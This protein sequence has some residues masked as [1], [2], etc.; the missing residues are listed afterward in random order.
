LDRGVD[1]GGGTAAVAA[2]LLGGLA[3][4]L[5]G[6]LAAL[7]WAC[8]W[9]F[10]SSL[11]V[12]ASSVTSAYLTATKRVLVMSS[13]LSISSLSLMRRRMREVFSVMTTEPLSG[14]M[15]P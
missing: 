7:F 1:G 6:W 9:V 3:G 5:G 14:A 2:R 15:E 13:G 10:S 4:D 12:V 11:R 8:C